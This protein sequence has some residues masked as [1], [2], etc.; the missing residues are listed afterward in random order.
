MDRQQHIQLALPWRGASA[1][2]MPNDTTWAQKMCPRLY[3]AVRERP[4]EEVAALLLQQHRAVANHT[5]TIEHPRCDTHEVTAEGNTVLHVAAEKGRSELIQGLYHKPWFREKAKGLLSRGNSA[6][7]TPLHCAARAGSDTSVA[8]LIELAEG[9]GESI[10]GCKNKAGDTALHVAARHGH[11]E[12]VKALLVSASA[13]EAAEVNKVGASP[14]YLAVM[15]GSVQAVKEIIDKC[16]DGASYAGPGSQNA[17]HAA[18][19]QSSKMVQLLM[20]WRPNLAAEGDGSGSSPLHYA[21]SD[22]DCKV[23][24][25]ILLAAPL[26]TV[27]KK[28][29]KAGLSALHVAA[30]MGHRRVV[31]AL[32]ERRPDAAELRDKD[33]RTFVHAAAAEARSPVVSLAIER[34]K[35]SRLRGLL[36]AQDAHGN[37]PLHLAVVNG[38]SGVVDA[39]LRKG[40]VRVDVLNND[41]HT[42]LDLTANSKSYFTM[43]S[44]VVTLVAFKASPQPKRQDH[45]EPWSIG[46]VKQGIEKSCDN[47]V[48]VAVLIATVAFAAGFNV[49]GGFT[50]GSGQANLRNKNNHPAFVCFL[51]FDT[52][53]V[54]TSVAAAILLVYGKASCSSGSW[55]SFSWRRC[56]AC[57]RRLSA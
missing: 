3:R 50:D 53:A 10:L 19:F 46:G 15:S 22:G 35:D 37:T 54:V 25:A 9:S 18:V 6:E 24:E 21:S 32:L 7:D 16:P 26:E 1:I 52:L 13:A 5:G 28:D 33:G 8:I 48:V 36:D 49:P 41:G 56:T 12:A 57:G 45:L 17:L 43:V 55:R 14:L 4:I 30:S 11:A 51:F 2:G 42:A 31:K 44:L 40:K 34:F 39:L 29:N 20:E 27:Y 38:A 23:V 47:L